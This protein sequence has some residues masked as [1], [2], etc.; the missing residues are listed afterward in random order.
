MEDIAAV[1]DG[2]EDMLYL[3]SL[4]KRDIGAGCHMRTVR[5]IDRQIEGGAYL[6]HR[7]LHIAFYDFFGIL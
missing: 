2:E 4:R 5:V 3:H 6:L 1:Y 7:G